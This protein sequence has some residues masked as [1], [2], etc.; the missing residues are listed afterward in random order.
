MAFSAWFDGVDELNTIAADLDRAGARV[1]RDGATAIRRS[2]LE[3]ERYGKMLC[4]VDTGATRA[5]IG[6]D[7]DGDG[8]SSVMSSATGPT[9]AYA[10]YVEWGTERMAPHAFMGPALDR[11]TPSFLA[12]VATLADPLAE[13]GG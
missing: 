13:A 4:P 2:A 12:A 8:R 9:T 7:F 6:S 5:S 10:P 1:G 3:I 11:V